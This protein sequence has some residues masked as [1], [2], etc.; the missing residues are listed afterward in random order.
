MRERPKMCK[1]ASKHLDRIA[2]FHE[3]HLAH[4]NFGK[5]KNK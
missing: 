1:K 5:L 2:E 3:A 4:I